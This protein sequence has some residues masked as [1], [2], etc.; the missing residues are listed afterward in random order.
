M[1]RQIRFETPSVPGF[2]KSQK[3]DISVNAYEHL[4][5]PQWEKA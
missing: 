1:S 2:P 5:F 3:Y 4:P